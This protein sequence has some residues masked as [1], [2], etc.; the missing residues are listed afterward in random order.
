MELIRMCTNHSKEDEDDVKERLRKEADV[1][2]EDARKVL[3]RDNN[4]CSLFVSHLLT[5]KK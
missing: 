1:D 5:Q 4:I 2:Q 3:Q